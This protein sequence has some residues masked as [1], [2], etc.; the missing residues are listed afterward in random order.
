[1]VFRAFADKHETCGN[2]R[3]NDGGVCKGIALF[4]SWEVEKVIT[5]MFKYIYIY[6]YIADPTT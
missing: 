5:C 1:M 2:N 3:Y 4:K 6:I